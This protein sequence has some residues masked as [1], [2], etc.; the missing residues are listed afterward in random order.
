MR[1]QSQAALTVAAVVVIAIVGVFVVMLFSE[2]GRN[3]VWTSL[4][5]TGVLIIFWPLVRK[6][7]KKRKIRLNAEIIQEEIDGGTITQH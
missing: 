6:N 1:K 3:Q 7:L 5:A 2:G 4:I